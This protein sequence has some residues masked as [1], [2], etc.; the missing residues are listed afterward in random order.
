MSFVPPVRFLIITP[1]YLKDNSVINNNVEENILQVVIRHAEDKYIHP[2]IGSRMMDRISL[3]ISS[4][5]TGGTI[6]PAYK[7]LIDEYVTPCL[8]EYS[9]YEYV[10]YTFKFRNKGVSRQGG[11]DTLPADLN[12]LGYIRETVLSSAIFYGERLVKYLKSNTTTFTEYYQYQLG[13]IQPAKG[14]TDFPLFIPN[15]NRGDNCGTY[16]LGLG[17]DIDF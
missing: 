16:G 1:Q 6:D 15:A 12:D 10:P 8:I 3:D 2:L 9:I 11:P 7:T 17:I 4:Y 5:V 13:D 14:D